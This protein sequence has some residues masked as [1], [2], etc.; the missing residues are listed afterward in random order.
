MSEEKGNSNE[1]VFSILAYIW[2]LFI[3]GLLADK[4]NPNVKFHVNQGIIL[5]IFSIVVTVGVW[6]LRFIPVIR[7][8]VGILNIV[9][10]I[11]MIIGIINAAKGENKPLP[12]IGGFEIL[13]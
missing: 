2:F 5:F 11:F 9:P 3:V 12:I 6:V 7:S 13:K 8:F 1:K 10:F 4:D